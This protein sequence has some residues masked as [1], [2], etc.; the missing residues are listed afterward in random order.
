MKYQNH[1]SL[2]KRKG[3]SV[4]KVLHVSV[5]CLQ[6]QQMKSEGRLGQ[7]SRSTSHSVTSLDKESREA[8]N[9]PQVILRILTF[10]NAYSSA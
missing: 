9:A 7:D 1:E 4:M 5:M 2:V 3:Y 10:L 6:V 8:S